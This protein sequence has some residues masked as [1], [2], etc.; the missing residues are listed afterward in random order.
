MVDVDSRVRAAHHC[1]ALPSEPCV[2]VVLA[3]GSSN[4]PEDPSSPIAH[5]PKLVRPSAPF[6][7]SIDPHPTFTLRLASFT[8]SFEQLT[9]IASAP[10]RVELYGPIRRV[11]VSPCLSANPAFASRSFLFPLGG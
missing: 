8:S 3:H 5:G 2:R 1:A 7:E 11:M 9:R 6:A 4:L 10:F